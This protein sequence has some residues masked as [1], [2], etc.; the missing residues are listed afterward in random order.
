[1]KRAVL[2]AGLIAGCGTADQSLMPLQVGQSARYAVSADFIRFI[3]EVKVVR[4][5]A[6]AGL[7][8]F[9]LSGPMGE[10][11]V[12]WKGD[13]LI[14]DRF[15]NTRFEPAIPLVV[16]TDEPVQRTWKGSVQGAWGKYDAV[17]TLAQRR[18]QEVDGKKLDAIKSEL[19][20][21]SPNRKAIKLV[22]TFRPGIGI[23]SQRQW[24][25]GDSIAEIERISGS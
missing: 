19:T 22:T 16:G 25:G 17:A 13:T 10:S 2:L 14:G 11:H 7:D 23:H 3:G 20:I 9:V 15:S 1:M 24:V 6:V 18:V 21:T 8:G 5:S 12:A 4:R